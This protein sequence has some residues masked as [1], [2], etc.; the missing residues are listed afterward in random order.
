MLVG[1]Y[2]FNFLYAWHLF[3]IQ[4][5][6]PVVLFP[7]RRFVC[8]I[9]SLC[10]KQRG[11]INKKNQKHTKNDD[12]VFGWEIQLWSRS[13]CLWLR[14]TSQGCG[15]G[16]T[17]YDCVR[18][19]RA[20]VKEP[21]FMTVW[22]FAE[23]RSKSHCLWLCETSQGYGHINRTGNAQCPAHMPLWRHPIHFNY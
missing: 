18:L 13:H 14:E 6:N 7:G 9:L 23:L 10:L 22:D 21:L 16:A 3:S 12:C 5:R 2:I 8:W 1:I 19:R 15:Q 11:L 20:A 4:Y 17:A